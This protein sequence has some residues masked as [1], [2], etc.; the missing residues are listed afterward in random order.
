MAEINFDTIDAR[1]RY[2]L[3]VG[4]V[5][6]RPIALVTSISSN[7]TVN[8]AP[9][10]FFNAVCNDPPAVFVGVNSDFDGREKDTAVN[11]RTSEEFV[12]NMVDEALC[13]LMNL[14]EIEFPHGIGEPEALGLQTVSAAR[15]APPRLS[16]APISLEC[17]L[18]QTVS[19]A[20]GKAM[21]IGRVIHMHVDDRL[22]D[23]E[24]NYVLADRARI[25]GRMHGAGEYVRTTDLFDMP[26]LSTEEKHRRFGGVLKAPPN[27]GH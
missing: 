8:A 21:F 13:P 3:L 6:P 2:K 25:V 9:F 23:A 10:S 19:L 22:Y 11:I 27:G 15:V 20:P 1:E 4:A 16:A 5:V 14:C 26:R 12:V 7:G 17:R 18:L 24:K